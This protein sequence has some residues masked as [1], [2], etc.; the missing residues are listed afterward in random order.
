[1]NHVSDFMNDDSDRDV[2][3]KLSSVEPKLFIA[4]RV[5]VATSRAYDAP[6][7]WRWGVEAAKSAW[8]CLELNLDQIGIKCRKYR[9]HLAD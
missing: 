9:V 8:T 6:M 1:M 5:S 2:V 3:A 4:K 7:T